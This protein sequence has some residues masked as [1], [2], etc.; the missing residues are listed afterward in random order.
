MD[1]KPGLEFAAQHEL[2][3]R[4]IEIILLFMEGDRTLDEAATA[5]NSLKTS[6]YN[7]ILRLKIKGLIELKDKKEKGVV[8]YGFKMP[9]SQE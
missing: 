9:P 8:V 2:T 6:L 3:K 4:E 1:I 5:L 7:T